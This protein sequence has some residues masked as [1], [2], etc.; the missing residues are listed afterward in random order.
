MRHYSGGLGVVRC[1]AA[2]RACQ[3]ADLD[4]YGGHDRR[5]L[6]LEHRLVVLDEAANMEL[7]YF[8]C[9]RERVL[10]GV[11]LGRHAEEGHEGSVSTLF[12]WIQ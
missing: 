3:L 7:G 12:G 10:D 2:S 11:P 5:L 4:L 9:H 6:F 1:Q 8:A